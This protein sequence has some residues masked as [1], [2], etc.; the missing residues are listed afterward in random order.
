MPEPTL[1]C[2][3]NAIL[4]QNYTLKLLRYFLAVLA[5]GEI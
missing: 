1:K 4:M 3:N 5:E 2:E